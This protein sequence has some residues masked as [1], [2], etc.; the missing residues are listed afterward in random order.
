M[1]VNANV[2]LRLFVHIL[3]VDWF[4][5]LHDDVLL[6]NTREM[7]LKNLVCIVDADWDDRAA[8]F[9]SYFERTFMEWKDRE[10][11]AFVAGSFWENENGD[12]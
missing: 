11:F 10:F 12:A 5:V 9:L 2:F 6:F 4:S 8:R 3:H 7:R 1:A